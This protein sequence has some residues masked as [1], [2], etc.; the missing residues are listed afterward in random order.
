MRAI[1]E[2]WL[3]IMLKIEEETGLDPRQLHEYYAH[4]ISHLPW[5]EAPPSHIAQKASQ[6]RH[7]LRVRIHRRIFHK[8]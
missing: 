4:K 8:P 5:C 1:R 7:P 6:T 3:R 2:L